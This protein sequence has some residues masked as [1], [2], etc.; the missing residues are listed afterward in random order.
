MSEVGAHF[1]QLWLPVMGCVPSPHYDSIGSRRRLTRR[2]RAAHVCTTV[3]LF[4]VLWNGDEAQTRERGRKEGRKGDG[5]ICSRENQYH[6]GTRARTYVTARARG[7]RALE[8]RG[9]RGKMAGVGEE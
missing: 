1:T 7:G 9:G 5:I 6:L 3:V 8:F 2:A 4:V